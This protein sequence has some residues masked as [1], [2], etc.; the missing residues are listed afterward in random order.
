MKRFLIILAAMASLTACFKD[1]HVKQKYV[2]EATFQYVGVGFSSDSTYVNT[3]E[4]DGFGYDA[5]NFY[6]KLGEDK[7]FKGGFILSCAEMPKSGNTTGLM[8]TYRANLP[9]G[10]TSGNI[11]TVYHQNADE[12][13]M[14]AHDVKYAFIENGDCTM[15]GC[16]VTN[17]VEVADFVKLHFTDGDRLSV[18]ATGYLNGAKTGEAE[19]ALAEFT[20]KKDSIV[21]KWTPFELTKLGTVDHVDFEIISTNP[22]VPAYFCMDSMIATIQIEY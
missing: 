16:Y 18:K 10:L 20:E 9:T 12:T 7:S 1:G 19:M 8:N 5:L 3:K 22:D 15:G 6:H 13:L 17:T 21:S 2:L 14:P 11:Y 4:I